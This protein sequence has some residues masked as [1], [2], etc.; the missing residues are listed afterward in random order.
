MTA[1][2]AERVRQAKALTQLAAGLDEEML[3]P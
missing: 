3:L 2:Q 1:K